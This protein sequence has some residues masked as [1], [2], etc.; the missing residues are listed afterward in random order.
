MELENDTLQKKNS[1]RVQG[2]RG[3]LTRSSSS[4][5]CWR[6]FSAACCCIQTS[7]D[8]LASC[9]LS[10]TWVR[11]VSDKPKSSSLS[12]SFESASTMRSSSSTAPSSC[13]LCSISSNKLSWNPKTSQTFSSQVSL[14]ERRVRQFVA[15]GY[16][17][18]F[19]S[20]RVASVSSR[21]AGGRAG[22]RRQLTASVRLATPSSLRCP[23]QLAASG[24]LALPSSCSPWSSCTAQ[25]GASAL[26][27]SRRL[28]ARQ[29]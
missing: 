20:S 15:V 29:P 7:T 12:S 9:T 13:S 18:A 26:C 8:W 14:R 19:F 10:Q 2:T 27:R 6:V 11:A 28:S 24:A 21:S 17:K 4:L 22:H 23:R 5:C 3:K 1:A 25:A 16:S